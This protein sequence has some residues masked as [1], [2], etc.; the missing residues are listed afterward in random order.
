MQDQLV[1]SHPK[2]VGWIDCCCWLD[3][4]GLCF[5]GDGATLTKASVMKPMRSS[6]VMRVSIWRYHDGKLELLSFRGSWVSEF[7]WITGLMEELGA[8]VVVAAAIRIDHSS[9]AQ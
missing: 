1:L 6:L 4:S 5:R 9:I 3:F 7:I 8:V 2:V